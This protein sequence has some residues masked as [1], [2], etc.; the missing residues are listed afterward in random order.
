MEEIKAIKTLVDKGVITKE[1]GYDLIIKSEEKEVDIIEELPT[2]PKKRKST[3]TKKYVKGKKRKYVQSGDYKKKNPSKRGPKV[4]ISGEP[5][6][7]CKS[8]NTTN[9]GIRKTKKFGEIQRFRCR[10]C[11]KTFSKKMA[12]SKAEADSKELTEKLQYGELND[13][14]I[15]FIEENIG[16]LASDEIANQLNRP[17]GI[18]VGKRNELERKKKEEEDQRGNQTY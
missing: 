8:K 14:E 18:I 1:E 16:V 11:N 7:Y 9:K 2:K 6:P 5:C 15:K 10:D 4:K 3:K 12:G 17:L 13:K